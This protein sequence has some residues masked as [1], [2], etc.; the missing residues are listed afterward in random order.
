MT[1]LPVSKRTLPTK[2]LPAGDDARPKAWLVAPEVTPGA[3]RVPSL[4]LVAEWAAASF[5]PSLE[6]VAAWLVDRVVTM[7]ASPTAM[8][9]HARSAG[10]EEVMLARSAAR[11]QFAWPRASHSST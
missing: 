3:A 1:R 4:E 8:E 7:P 10:R 11:A 5:M 6:L 9:E 2:E